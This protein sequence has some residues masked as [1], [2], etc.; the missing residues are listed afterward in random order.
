MLLTGPAAA[1]PDFSNAGGNQPPA[2]SHAPHK[3]PEVE[4]RVKGII[5]DK[6]REFRD[7]NDNGRLDPYE[8]WRLPT[9][10]RA[11]DL[12]SRMTLEEKAGMM[13]ISSLDDERSRGGLQEDDLRYFIIRD[14]PEAGELAIRNN[15]FQELAEA[16][17]LGIPVVMTSNP[18]NHVNP[19]QEFGISE[20]TG[21]FSVW[22]GE[23]G[24]A[25]TRDPALVKEFAEIAAEE[26][27]ASGIQKGYMYMA[28]VATDP[29]W[30]R[31]DGT[32]GE[33][34]DLAADMITS[35]VEGFQGEE[36]GA[37]SVSLT[38]K[39]FTGGGARLDGTDPHHEWGQDQVFPT[40]GSMDDYH[41]APFEAAIEAGTTSIMPYYAKPVNE[42]SA[43]QLPEEL[44]YTEDQQFEEVAFAYNESILRG[45]LRE[46]MGFTGYINSD[47]GII[48][49][50]PWGVEDLTEPER[51]A[52]AIEAGTNLF[53]G[54]SDPAPLIEA[55]EAGLVEESDL[56]E[57]ITFLISEMIDLGLFEN[58]YVDPELAQEI[59]DDPES[60]ALA[61]EANRRS[62]VL[63]RND[64]NAL[65]I[66]DD[67]VD[68]VRLYV[69]VFK[70]E[71]AAQASA[72]LAESIAEYDPSVTLVD[73]PEEATHSYLWVQPSL[74]WGEDDT[75]GDPP[76]V[77]LS[78]DSDTGIDAE[79]ILALQDQVDTT[80]L[81]INMT[82]PWL[83]GEIEPGADAVLATFNVTPEAVVDVVRGEHNPTGRLPLTV[84]VDQEAVD[85]NAI[86]VPGYAEG[87]GYAYVNG[88]GDTYEYGFGLSYRD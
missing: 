58:P 31:T 77:E 18:R 55:V 68:D 84:P 45:L 40:E 59:A 52:K 73:D 26:W 53:S 54:G 43:V 6:G 12:V 86:D 11:A 65:P 87:P 67:A 33:D 66:T 74:S 34:P 51:Y 9:E 63:M 36:L 2:H 60:Q 3:A 7:L 46:E 5:K 19:D 21:Q 44:W 48:G 61:D 78:K 70:E 41:M 42:G 79:R 64:Q 22:P 56:D 17:R 25:A 20:A 75:E 76:S 71:D 1:A 37:G 72:D 35:I 49:S 29:R 8:D 38:T 14:N 39:H 4:S 30:T 81:G 69:E 15:D 28:D 16:S 82:N 27:R 57:S 47:T 24:L 32:F 85:S 83:I 88:I 50:R 23:L 10:E 13:L 62:I 80:I